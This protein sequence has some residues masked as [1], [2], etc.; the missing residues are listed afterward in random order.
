[1]LPV[2]S[3][4]AGCIVAQG[5]TAADQ[6]AQTV[7]GQHYSAASGATPQKRGEGIPLLR[8]F[9]T[10]CIAFALIPI[11][12]LS[13]ALPGFDSRT[14]NARGGTL[15]IDDELNDIQE[16]LISGFA[17][18]TLGK[19][20]NDLGSSHASVTSY[21]PR[22]SDA[23]PNNISSNIKVN[24][25][26]LNLS[27]P[28]LQGRGQAQNESFI[29]VD[30]N[31]QNHIVASYNDYRRGDGTCGVSYSLDGGR[32][33]NDSTVPNGF[34]R[35]NQ[36][37]LAPRDYLQASGDTSVDWDSKGNAYLSCQM[38]KRGRATTGDPEQSSG[39]YV[40]RSTQNNGASFDFPARPVVETA[41]RSGCTPGAGGTAGCGQT[42]FLPLQDKQFMAIDHNATKCA[43]AVTMATPGAKCT[44]FQDRIYV[45]W[46]EFAPNGTAFIYLSYSSDYAEHF[47]T[48][49]LVS[50]SSPTLCPNDYGLGTANTCN[51]NQFSQPF[52]GPD[53]VLYVIFNNFNN[54][55]T[56]GTTPDN[57]N[58]I[59]ISRSF[60]GGN[61]F[62]TPHKVADYYDL[63]DCATYQ[64]GHD[65]GR[66]C[67]PEKG[68]TTNSIFRA[69]N[70]ASG[71]VNPTNPSQIV[72]AV[73]SYIN[74]HSK[75]SNGCVPTSFSPVTG[76][77]LYTGVKT[78][79]ACNN[80][81][82]VSVS[83]DGGA[84]FTGATTDPR[85]LAVATTDEGQA[86]TDQWWQWIAFT[87]NGK[88]AI[89][90]Y[91]R[92]Y[93]TDELTG[94]SDVS[95]SGSGDSPAYDS[96]GVQRVTSSSM[97]VPTQFPDSSGFSTFWGDYA[98]LTASTNANPFWSDTRDPDLFACPGTPAGI[99][100]QPPAICGATISAGNQTTLNDQNMYTANV[101]VP[102][103]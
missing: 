102:S 73:G 33:W 36:I 21:F 58:Q 19:T 9:A 99:I 26:C 18:F 74:K 79:G 40:F 57:R 22:G 3:C 48:R 16:R 44:P 63:P 50:L 64:G 90:Y 54:P 35:G 12:V 100:A 53:G 93:G 80:D 46:T 70:Y 28:D 5:S 13:G 11:L 52:V 27:D 41:P 14:P 30:P 1:V 55:E 91:D 42:S 81:I 15:G 24:Q 47:S 29:K 49:K 43:A 65:F 67:V 6:L 101:S 88:L 38:F 20:G 84:T 25:N 89:S 69:A 7:S 83:N 56:F 62:E 17:A 94:Y 59:L 60:N 66:A 39:M 75:E 78:V 72:V 76:Q 95:L 4:A 97:P 31:N 85:A 87:K 77:N 98:G 34:V 8:R 96:W 82:L 71:E 86:T 61:T 2:T 45:S 32:T 68:P 92:Q 103:K 51:E 37:N 23:C 10:L